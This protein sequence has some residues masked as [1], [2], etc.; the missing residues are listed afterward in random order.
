MKQR[1]T[2]LTALLGTMVIGVSAFSGCGSAEPEEPLASTGQTVVQE[3]VQASVPAEKE[4][5]LVA[6]P[7]V[8]KYNFLRTDSVRRANLRIGN[9]EREI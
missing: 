2:K 9:T 7:G 6:E 8:P 4:E 3:E 1:F 5:K